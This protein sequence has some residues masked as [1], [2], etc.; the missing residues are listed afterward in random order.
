MPEAVLHPAVVATNQRIYV[1]GGEDPMQNPLRI[2][3][4][5]S[6]AQCHCSDLL[7][8]NSF[9]FLHCCPVCPLQVY[10]IGRN[11]WCK[12]ENRMVKNVSAPAAIIDDKIYIIGGT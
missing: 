10:H 1:F 9:V 5:N 8:M 12:M 4:V 2:I 11:M 7:I 3:Q 6:F